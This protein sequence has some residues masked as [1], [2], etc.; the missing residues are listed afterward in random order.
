MQI[1]PLRSGAASFSK[2]CKK[3]VIGDKKIWSTIEPFMHNKECHG[4]NNLT[5]H[6]GGNIAT[7]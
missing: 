1:S 4:N 5:L 6:E 3:G 7:D 2:L